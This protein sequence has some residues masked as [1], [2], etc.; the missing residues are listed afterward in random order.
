MFKTCDTR[1]MQSVS[2]RLTQAN[3]NVDKCIWHRV[4]DAMNILALPR[5]SRAQAAMWC[6]QQLIAVVTRVP[7]IRLRLR[8]AEEGTR[9]RRAEESALLDLPAVRTRSPLLP[10]HTKPAPPSLPAGF[11]PGGSPRGTGAQPTELP[12]P[13]HHGRL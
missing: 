6:Y 1:I 13:Q 8:C 3:A 10:V 9:S 11:V 5:S 7:V 2:V 4:M 12:E